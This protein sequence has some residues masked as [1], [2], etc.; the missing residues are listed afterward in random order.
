[1]EQGEL[2]SSSSSSSSSS[3]ST[4]TGKKS[5]MKKTGSTNKGQR[6]QFA[7]QLETYK[8]QPKTPEA[9]LIE[10]AQVALP[11]A[12]EVIDLCANDFFEVWTI[13]SDQAPSSDSMA[14]EAFEALNDYKK[15]Y[16]FNTK[17]LDNE[18]THILKQYKNDALDYE[19]DNRAVSE[20]DSLL[21]DY[22]N[23][24]YNKAKMLYQKKNEKVLEKFNT[25]EGKTDQEK[26]ANAVTLGKDLLDNYNQKLELVG[27]AFKQYPSSSAYNYTDYLS[28][29]G[30]KRKAER[31]IIIERVLPY[32]EKLGLNRQNLEAAFPRVF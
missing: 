27:K 17:R 13:L 18:F 22:F 26:Y 30:A 25:I 3:A 2:S 7:Q 4:Q 29:I 23:T 8:A 5:A 19:G 24:F 12:Q 11:K 32:A 20:L 1:M 14:K 15:S 6:V 21:D 31:E 10:Y 16:A 9:I 28:Y